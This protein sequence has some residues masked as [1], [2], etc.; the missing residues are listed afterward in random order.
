MFIFFSRASVYECIGF[1]CAR[2]YKGVCV[3]MCVGECKGVS[4]HFMYNL[5]ILS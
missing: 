2:M 3:C 5:C 1:I 4:V